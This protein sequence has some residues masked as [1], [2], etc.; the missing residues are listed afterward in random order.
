MEAYVHLSRLHRSI[1]QAWLGET[2]VERRK[3]EERGEK[4][5]E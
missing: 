5:K 4:E 1:Q 2:E 3:E